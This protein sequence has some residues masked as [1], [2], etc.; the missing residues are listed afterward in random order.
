MCEDPLCQVTREQ[1]TRENERL[2]AKAEEAVRLR[3]FLREF[4]GTLAEMDGVDATE[5][6][7]E[8]NRGE[9]Q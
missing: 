3:L 7:A 4:V 2:R 5:V 9:Q 1:L 8:V 6:L